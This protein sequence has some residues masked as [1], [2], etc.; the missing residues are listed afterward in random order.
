MGQIVT[1]YS[2]K[3]GV[4]RSMALAN[5]AALLARWGYKTLIVDWDLEAPGLE[6]FF[7]DYTDREHSDL[8]A[9]TERRGLVDL[10]TA[11][12]K[13]TGQDSPEPNWRDFL[14]TIKLKDSK[15]PL[16]LLTAGQRSTEYFQRVR[17]FDAQ[18]Y[19]REQG[20]G[21]F[22]EKLRQEWKEEYQLVLIDSRT[23]VTDIGGICTIHLPDILVL[24]F[25]ATEQGL[26][27]AV[28]VARKAT[29]AR[30]NLPTDR[31]KLLTIPLPSR[32]DDSVEFET[33]QKWLDRFSHEVSDLYA[34]WLPT[35][36]RR[37]EMLELTKIPYRAYFSFGEKLAVIEQGTVDPTGLGYAMETLTALIA[38]NLRGA[39][40]LR[41]NRDDFVKLAA[42]ADSQK[43]LTPEYDAQAVS[44]AVGKHQEWLA[45]EGTRGSLANFNGFKLRAIDL[46]RAELPKASLVETD[47]NAANL[48]ETNLSAAD[49]SRST[50]QGANLQGAHLSEANLQKSSLVDAN[51]RGAD[52]TGADLQAANLEGATLTDT[53]LSGANLS[54]AN[55]TRAD[56]KN[57]RFSDANLE[58]AVLTHASGLML[59]QLRGANLSKALLP[60]DISGYKGLT[61]FWVFRLLLFILAL[62]QAYSLTVIAM[63]TDAQLMTDTGLPLKGVPGHIF[64]MWAPA[65]LFIIYVAFHSYLQHLW[66]KIARL[67]AISP[68]GQTLDETLHEPFIAS[69][70]AYYFKRLGKRRLSPARITLFIW[71]WVLGPLVL[72]LFWARY[73]PRHDWMGTSMHIIVAVGATLIGIKSYEM[74]AK[75]LSGN[76]NPAALWIRE[77][78]K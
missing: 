24:V 43:L 33:S 67:P 14:V 1:F 70:V 6:N 7:K 12:I 36:V 76:E 51:L 69:M 77:R 23:G 78:R 41:I 56:L 68:E 27:G 17:D 65:V 30:Q 32:F 44:D 19:Y 63:A 4:G 46:S 37:R 21:Y 25:T 72:L 62:A 29:L 47:L 74:T 71:A 55:L 22:I 60:A 75:V 5:T 28:N 8:D 50:L 31:L 2:Y 73:L 9:I 38:N 39:D 40:R 10:I 48:S 16:H 11:S 64:F 49:L 45:S 57:A 54:E 42:S 61:S 52:L 20:G 26:S 18:H 34:D 3:G 13:E 58:K 15:A 53:D 59:H 35:D 66:I